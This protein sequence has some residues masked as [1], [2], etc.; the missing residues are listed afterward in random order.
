MKPVTLAAVVALLLLA[1]PACP[2]SAQAESLR[3]ASLFTDHMVLQRDQPVPVWGWAKPGQQITVEFAGQRKTTNAGSS[4]KW[5]TE[6]DPLSASAEGRD[7][8]VES[9]TGTRKLRD[10]VVGDVW[11]ASGQSNMHFNMQKVHNAADEIAAARNSAIR[12]FFV[13]PQ[14]AREPATDVSGE[15]LPV[16]P[17]TVGKCSAVAYYFAR[18]L[19]P[20]IGVPVGL[21]ASSVGGIRIETW[22]KAGILADLGTAEPLLEKWRNVPAQEFQEILDANRA[23]EHQ[24]YTV[25]P[26]LVRKAKREGEPI[27]PEPKRPEKRPHECPGALHDGMIAPLQPFALRGVLWYQ[28][29]GNMGNPEAYEKMLPAMIADWRSVWGAEMPFLI[30]QLPP[31][32]NITPQFRESQFRIW[33]NTPHTAMVASTDVG[34]AKDLHPPHK[35]P[36]GERLALAARALS[37]GQDVEFSGPVFRSMKVEGDRAVISFT[38]VGRGLLAK[39]DSLDGFVV[40][41]MDGKFFPGTAVIEGST[42]VVSAAEVAKPE[43][44]QFGHDK[45]PKVNFFNREGLPAVP[46]RSDMPS[47]AVPARHSSRP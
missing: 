13:E 30:V 20:E 44:V 6:L 39:G 29:E 5:L 3:L 17:E 25:H 10:V 4:G 11:L 27:P 1:S 43:F 16:S 38:H 24:L 31:H 22:I 26:E 32:Q 21:L 40:A 36:I 34:E 23:H 12:F 15:W 42:V 46:F 8:V 41:G 14:F 45:V 47:G 7:L 9:P 35:R 2:G 18:D 37:Y 28:G 19:Q 33:Q